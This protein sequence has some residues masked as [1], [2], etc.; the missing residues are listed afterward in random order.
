MHNSS[1]KNILLLQ[2]NDNTTSIILSI[3]NKNSDKIMGQFFIK[4][5]LFIAIQYIP[6]P[7]PE[8]E[9]DIAVTDDTSSR[10]KRRS[11]IIDTDNVDDEYCVVIK[12]PPPTPAPTLGP[13]VMVPNVPIITSDSLNYTLDIVNSKCLFWNVTLQEFESNGCIVSFP[14]YSAYYLGL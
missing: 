12:P 14:F 4:S 1:Q 8:E 10:R 2:G 7:T 5:F 6:P 11:N 13:G 9:E 3:Q